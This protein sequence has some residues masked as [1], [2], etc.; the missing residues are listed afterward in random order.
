MTELSVYDNDP[1]IYLFTSLTAGSSHII[2]ATSRIETILRANKI[3]FKGVDTAT[4]ELA[5]K[6]F[7]RRASGKK[8]PLIVKE[9]YVLGGITEIEE[10]NEYDEIR[11][12]LGVTSAFTPFP[13]KP[14]PPMV[15]AP[16]S[17]IPASAAAKKENVVIPSP[18]T[19]LAL[20]QLGA[21]AAKKA[22]SLKPT[23]TS[24]K[25]TNPL[26][27]EKTNTPTS[28]TSGILSPKSVPLPVTPGVANLES[29]VKETPSS[30]LSP[31]S[32]P[33]PDT[34]TVAAAK[35]PM[36]E[37]PRSKDAKPKTTTTSTRKPAAGGL[38]GLGKPAAKPRAKATTVKDTKSKEA[39]KAKDVKTTR[40]TA[41]SGIP[42]PTDAKKTTK[43]PVGGAKKAAVAAGAVGAAGAAAAV[44]ATTE[45][46]D[47]EDKKDEEESPEEESEGEKSE[48]GEASKPAEA[49]ASDAADKT[50]T[51]EE[52]SEEDDEEEET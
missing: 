1:T 26:L 50:A 47:E 12:A 7:Q 36:K 27:S 51:T 8:L 49:E 23:P 37:T 15:S 10:W 34:P 21:E 44:A 13:A 38:F 32:V 24:I 45:K 4:D 46:K 18:E 25:T 3:P 14:G 5:K 16:S 40:P 41:R 11:E 28:A 48:G 30:I 42:K 2:T 9:G 29:P 20:R 6:L 52:S 43:T 33:L 17:I 39:V 31:K 22:A 35:S 19:N